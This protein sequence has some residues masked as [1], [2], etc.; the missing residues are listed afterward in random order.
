MLSKCRDKWDSRTCISNEERDQTY[1]RMR[2]SV[3]AGQMLKSPFSPLEQIL[4]VRAQVVSVVMRKSSLLSI[5]ADVTVQVRSFCKQIFSGVTGGATVY[6]KIVRITSDFQRQKYCRANWGGGCQKKL[7]LYV[8]WV[9]LLVCEGA[10]KQVSTLFRPIVALNT[11]SLLTPQLFSLFILL[12]YRGTSRSDARGVTTASMLE[13][14]WGQAALFDTLS[15]RTGFSNMAERI[16]MPVEMIGNTFCIKIHG[17][18]VVKPTDL[19]PECS[20]SGTIRLKF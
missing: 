15:V 1:G 4:R 16:L 9:I 8:C 6:N 5:Q 2:W 14:S 20:S 13:V 10:K 12:H 11:V 7:E 19:F 17:S 18:Q 3:A